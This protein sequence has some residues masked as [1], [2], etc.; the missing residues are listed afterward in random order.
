MCCFI[1]GLSTFYKQLSNLQFHIKVHQ[2][3]V[4]SLVDSLLTLFSVETRLTM[5]PH[6]EKKHTHSIFDVFLSNVHL[7]VEE[8]YRM[9]KDVILT[10]VLESALL[11]LCSLLNQILL[12]FSLILHF[13][14]K[15]CA[16]RVL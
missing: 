16:C 6:L 2:M 1:S 7:E 4:P 8:G 13:L 10:S 11:G 5:L 12:W 15:H 14:F 3:E 9:P